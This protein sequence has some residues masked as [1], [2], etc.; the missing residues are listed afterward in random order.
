M[1]QTYKFQLDNLLELANNSTL[2]V[3]SL[4]T[5][6]DNESVRMLTPK[7][8]A[9]NMNG[10]LVDLGDG[11][12]EVLLP[13]PCEQNHAAFLSMGADGLSCLWF[14]GSLEGCSDISIW[15]SVLG[16]GG[17]AEAEQVSFDA[18]RSEQNPV[19]FD[20]PD[21]RRIVLH[22]AQSGG[23]QD[24]S[25]VRMLVQGAAPRD[26]PLPPGVFVRAPVQVRADGV[27]L[28]PLFKC[29]ARPGQRWTGSH[30]T[31]ALAISRDAGVTWRVVDV[32]QSMG[33]VHMTL[34]PLGPDHYAA[35]FRRRQSD[36]VYRCESR[37]GGET[38]SIP[39]PTDVPNN[40]SSISV[41]R[42]QGGQVAMACN[43]VNAAMF[44][45]AKRASLYDE[46]GE[47]DDRPNADGGCNP[48]WGTPRAPMVLA[49]SD[50]GGQSFAKRIVVEDGP[51]TCLSNNSTDGKNAELSYPSLVE[52]AQGTLHLAYTYHRRAIKYVRLS[53]Q[54][55]ETQ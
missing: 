28:L 26:L 51:G 42:L 47:D 44:P 33:C 52:D 49:L 25:V 55:L 38:W 32:A 31:A 10:R 45:D 2:L 18:H 7:E 40:N 14:G 19:Q 53:R 46:L 15:R 22:T 23:D 27:W 8:I 29:V 54:W 17:W 39:A 12:A 30:D 36:Y 11:R 20:A 35:F 1:C 21:G 37:D 3:I 43:P 13:S 41:I 24:A 9:A 16:E 48:V 6:R 34:V 50:D 4:A 5:S